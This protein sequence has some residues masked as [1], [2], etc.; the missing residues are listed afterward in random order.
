MK[1]KTLTE[2]MARH[3]QCAMYILDNIPYSSG[4][5]TET[6]SAHFEDGLALSGQTNRRSLEAGAAP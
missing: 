3:E 6:T 1:T 5:G 2:K 4:Q